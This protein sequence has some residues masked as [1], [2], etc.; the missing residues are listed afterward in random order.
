MASADNGQLPTSLEEVEAVGQV[1]I[2]IRSQTA[3][4]G[5]VNDSATILV[6]N[7]NPTMPLLLGILMP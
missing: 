7:E 1:L 6:T 4:W 5:L 3:I 2:V